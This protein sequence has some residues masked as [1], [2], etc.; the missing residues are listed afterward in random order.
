MTPPWG[1]TLCFRRTMAAVADNTYF[2]QFL[3]KEPTLDEII[4][5]V[6]VDEKWYQFGVLLNLLEDELDS[7]EK[8][9]Q[10][11]ASEFRTNACVETVATHPS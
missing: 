6:K 5:H 9:Y 7:I 4:E 1:R 8:L 10:D 11:R 2:Q 3:S